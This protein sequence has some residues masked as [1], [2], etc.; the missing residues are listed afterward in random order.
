MIL[1]YYLLYF[2]IFLF[3]INKL[4]LLNNYL[5]GIFY[6]STNILA[7]FIISNLFIIKFHLQLFRQVIT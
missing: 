5:N 7:L 3:F 6:F 1:Y 4:Y 2:Y